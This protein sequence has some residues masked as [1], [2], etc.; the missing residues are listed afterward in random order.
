[1]IITCTKVLAVWTER[2][3]PRS[4]RCNGVEQWLDRLLLNK[5]RLPL[6]LS[7]VEGQAVVR[8]HHSHPDQEYPILKNKRSQDLQDLYK[9]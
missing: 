1:M 6:F 5:S 4:L 2:A 8:G 3:G 7:A 9:K